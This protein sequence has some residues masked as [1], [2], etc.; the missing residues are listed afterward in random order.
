VTERSARIIVHLS[1]LHFGRV[2]AR[3]ARVLRDTLWTLQPHVIAISGDLTQR[4]RRS[5]F[6]RVSAFL[7]GLPTP[8]LIVPGNHDVPLYNVIARLFDPLGGYKQFITRELMPT[9]MVDGVWLIGVNTT[10]PIRWKSGRIDAETLRGVEASVRRAPAT[11][12]KILVAHHPFDAPGRETA[13][14][15]QLLTSAGIDVFLTG[16]LHTSYAGQTA[17]RYNVG[18]RSA[19]V[20]EAATATSTRLRA[21]A[22]GF[23]VLRVST[24]SVR[25]QTYTWQH[26]AFVANEAQSFSRGEEGWTGGEQRQAGR[27]G[28]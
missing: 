25:V 6:R 1:D 17:Q 22:N 16:H 20:V 27:S 11:A 4:A 21:E 2:D 24:G 28:L 15:L 18:G 10:R 26:D 8:H 7:Q 23:N 5:E 13:P 9:I 14:S 12:V 3:V 19:V